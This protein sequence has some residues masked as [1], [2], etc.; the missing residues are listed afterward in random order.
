MLTTRQI[1]TVDH[2]ASV[3]EAGDGK[4]V[5]LFIHGNS[6]AKECFKPQFES[7]LSN[8]YRLIAIDL[9]GHGETVS[10]YN[11][12]Q[13]YSVALLVNFL[14]NLIRGLNIKECILLGHSLGGHI[15]I[16]AA[17]ELP[18]VRGILAW[19]MSPLTFDDVG[20]SP[21]TEHPAT[22]LAF[23]GTL[24]EK[25]IKSLSKGYWSKLSNPPPEILEMISKT[26]PNFRSSIHKFITAGK[27]EDEVREISKFSFPVALAV[28]E[29]DEMINQGYIQQVVAERLWKKK[30]HKIPD[31]G[32]SPHIENP[33][34]FNRFAHTFIQDV[35]G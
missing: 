27:F 9:P 7:S 1:K 6:M 31:A 22:A 25:D 32:H 15:A 13:A 26:D 12:R 30:L 4:P 21:F 2:I 23:S 17:G 33:D 16:E 10:K 14:R 24:D 28:G 18:E 29:H 3:Q 34:E 19:G 20:H 8:S 5:I 35:L 11:I